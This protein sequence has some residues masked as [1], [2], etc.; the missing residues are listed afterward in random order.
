MMSAGAA[1]VLVAAAVLGLA[2]QRAPAVRRT[3]PVPRRATVPRALPSPRAGLVLVALAVLVVVE[4]IVGVAVAA[5]VGLRVR[6]EPARRRRLV[7]RAV[8]R[9]LPDAVDLFLLC[10][11]AG[12]SV[13]LAHPLVAA[14][15]APPLGPALTIAAA[16]ADGGSARADA[17]LRAL[18]PHGDRAR[19][20]AVTLADHLRYGVPL[21]PSLER[22]GDELRL[23]RQRRAE[24][25]ARRVPVRL[26]APLV[27]CVLPAFALLTVVPLLASSLRALPT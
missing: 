3:L 2:S 14:R 26:L 12:S 4:P 1:A 6:A 8:T 7:A 15:L 27:L 17:L 24:Q 16:E 19:R 9:S 13:A 25:E 21:M 22:L 10:T 18:A 23:D 11:C 20:L 5:A